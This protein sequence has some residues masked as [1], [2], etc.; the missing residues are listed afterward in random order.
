MAAISDIQKIVKLLERSFDQQPWYGPSVMETL[1]GISA[2]IANN[3]L[4]H[5]HSIIEIVLHMTAWR[6]FVTQQLKGNSIELSDQE[7]FPNP[8]TWEEALAGLNK[9]QSALLAALKAFPEECLND[10]VPS[11]EYRFHFMLNGIIQHDSYH[12]GQIA[13]LKKLNSN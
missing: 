13:L 6:N 10:K 12:T 3:R 2:D 4:P 1:K 5:S 9:S 8:T 7:N 11:R